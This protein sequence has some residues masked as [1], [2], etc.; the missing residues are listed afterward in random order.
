[1]ALAELFL[2]TSESRRPNK[3]PFLNLRW[4][5]P[6]SKERG[7]QERTRLVVEKLESMCGRLHCLGEK[8]DSESDSAAEMLSSL[9]IRSSAPA[10]I[11]QKQ[12]KD[13][14]EAITDKR[15][16]ASSL[17]KLEKK[18]KGIIAMKKQPVLCLAKKLAG[19]AAK[20]FFLSLS[21]LSQ[22]LFEA[23]VDM[24]T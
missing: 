6:P 13:L 23:D 4:N 22:V 24:A 20:Y 1:M 18:V 12:Y 8:A 21:F 9:I 17:M 7:L 3:Q 19:H 16:V 2:Q 10:Q 11:R 14:Q 5:L 15:I